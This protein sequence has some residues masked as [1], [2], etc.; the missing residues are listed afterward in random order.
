M[1][2]KL[3]DWSFGFFKIFLL[4]NASVDTSQLLKYD[5]YYYSMKDNDLLK[6][7]TTE[8]QH[9]FLPWNMAKKVNH[10]SNNVSSAMNFKATGLC[11]STLF[12]SLTSGQ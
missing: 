11:D 8:Y 5:Y 3:V 6:S 12:K 2:Y 10:I 7:K 9:L 1:F 4:T